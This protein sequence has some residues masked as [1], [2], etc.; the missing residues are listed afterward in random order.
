MDTKTFIYIVAAI[1]LIIIGVI[2]IY[3]GEHFG[4]VLD[5]RKDNVD[6][7][8]IT[9][10]FPDVKVFTNDS[11]F[12]MGLDKCIEYR[13]EQKGGNCVE[14]G[15]TGNAWYYPEVKYDFSNYRESKKVSNQSKDFKADNVDERNVDEPINQNYHFVFR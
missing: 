11:D 7:V 6:Y 1:L 8:D 12:R 2:V 9:K 10:Q 4:D 3:A 5:V 14:Y 15:I 13:N